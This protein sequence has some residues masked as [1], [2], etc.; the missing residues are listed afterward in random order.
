VLAIVITA[1]S[2][3]IPHV[4]TVGSASTTFAGPELNVRLEARF[5]AV[6]TLDM[7]I[8][9][10]PVRDTIVVSAGTPKP[11]MYCPTASPVLLAIV[12]AAD[13]SVTT[14]VTTF[15]LLVPGAVSGS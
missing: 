6:A 4:T 7:V 3:V 9:V 11:L 1:D 8:C 5:V 2:S 13:A 14:Q 10:E 12:T 15:E